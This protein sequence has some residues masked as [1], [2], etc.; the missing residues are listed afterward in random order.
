MRSAF[1]GLA[2]FLVIFIEIAGFIMVGSR[3]GIPAT[4]IFVLI[5]ML[6]GIYLLRSQGVSILM[7]MQNELIAGRV[8][9]REIA[10]SVMIV[11]G[12]ILL[13][14][15]GF[16]SDIISI[17]FFIQTMRNLIW[18]YFSKNF[19]RSHPHHNQEAKIIDLDQDDYHSE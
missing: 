13:I 14:I 18:R 16:V 3:I 9:N 5:S 12:A 2:I 8:P 17:M 4:L 19:A 11:I 7:R 6:A 10:E 1:S 15:P